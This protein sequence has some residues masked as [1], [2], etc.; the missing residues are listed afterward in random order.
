MVYLEGRLK[1]DK[2]EDQGEVKYYTK[3]V[4]QK[5]QF[6]DNRAATDELAETADDPIGE[7]ELDLTEAF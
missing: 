2:Y 1:T 6:L 7:E 3:V 4:A 5:V